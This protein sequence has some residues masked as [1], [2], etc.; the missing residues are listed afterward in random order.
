MEIHLLR[1]SI[2]EKDLND[3]AARH[4]PE[5]QPIENIKIR[6]AADGVHLQGVYPLFVNVK[7]ETHWQL[8]IRDG[9]VTATLAAF[10]AMMIPGNVFKSAILK[11]IA[12]AAKGE[13]W[14]K[15]EQDTI[16]VDVDGLLLKNGLSAHTNLAKI[17]CQDGAVV[18][19]SGT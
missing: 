3:L 17:I 2:S 14:L 18:V 19:E 9:K 12:D 4:L 8:G 13:G 16:I 7:F 10:K 6:I 1:A 11:F 15:V 5:D